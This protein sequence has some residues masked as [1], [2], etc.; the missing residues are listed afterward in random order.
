VIDWGSK[1]ISPLVGKFGQPAVLTQAGLTYPV[2]GIFD[3]AY[4]DV[5]VSDGMPVTTK[6][7]CFGFSLADLSVLPK[8]KDT[9]F[10]PA[11]PI[12]P[13]NDTNYIIREVQDD[14]H[15]WCRLLLTVSP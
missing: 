9:L 6:T 10:I 14:G 3:E 12:A 13:K 4:L 7:P 5:D 8:Q 15:G 11:A 2:D 1:V